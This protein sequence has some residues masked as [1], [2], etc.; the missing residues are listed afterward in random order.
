MKR[1]VF[2]LLMVALLLPIRGALA[3][4]GILCHV[5]GAP[6]ATGEAATSHHHSEGA[7]DSPGQSHSMQ[8]HHSAAP[9]APAQPDV[10]KYCSA[11][12][13]MPPVP[14]GD[15]S[16]RGLAATGSEPFAPLQFPHLGPFSSGLE[17]PP[18]TI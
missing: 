5:G 10:C 12:C 8:G 14:P 7:T 2:I 3:G 4:V 15:M 16:F 1:R 17:R 6:V 18:R 13:S 11:V 9:D